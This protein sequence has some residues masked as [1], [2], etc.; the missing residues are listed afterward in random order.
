MANR[1]FGE[2]RHKKM[3]SIVNKVDVLN[4]VSKEENQICVFGIED[5]AKIVSY[6]CCEV[7]DG[8]LHQGGDYM[9]SI[10]VANMSDCNGYTKVHDVISVSNVGVVRFIVKDIAI[11]PQQ[12]NIWISAYIR[13]ASGTWEHTKAKMYKGME[14]EIWDSKP[15]HIFITDK[16]NDVSL[17]IEKHSM[18]MFG[19]LL[20][21]QSIDCNPK[22]NNCST[23]I[24][25]RGQEEFKLPTKEELEEIHK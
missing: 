4:T 3:P 2:D 21:T 5:R 23:H 22:H 10:S 1:V 6:K 20:K 18:I 15:A 8:K 19:V 16:D 14:F 25:I 13:Q 24:N 11:V 7:E 17:C 12:Y 9:F